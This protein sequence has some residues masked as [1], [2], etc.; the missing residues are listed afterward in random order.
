[1]P[2]MMRWPSWTAG[3]RAANESSV[4]TMSATLRVAWLPLAM[5]TARFDFLSD[6]TSL[7]PSPIIAT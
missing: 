7:T 3:A 1:M 6:S 2:L 5:A 4:S